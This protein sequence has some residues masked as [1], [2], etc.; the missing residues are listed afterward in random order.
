MTFSQ[1]QNKLHMSNL[2]ILLLGPPLITWMDSP[3]EIERRI[4]RALLYYL[5]AQGKPISRQKLISVFWNNQP[6]VKA[7]QRLR[8]NLSRLRA[9]LPKPGL[10][11]VTQEQISLD[12]SSTYV[13]LLEFEN[14]IT[15]I[16]TQFINLSA[17]EID[18]GIDAALERICR[19]LKVDRGYVFQY[20]GEEAINT[21]E[22]CS[23]GVNVWIASTTGRTPR[24]MRR[25]SWRS[26]SA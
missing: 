26:T 12:F 22:W 17:G 16:S 6:R 23:T 9:Q 7:R 2:C 3:I 13:D 5:A 19:F 25:T 21:H 24:R 10:L 4:P 18:G 11:E 20:S 15:E 14:I 1:L 8:E